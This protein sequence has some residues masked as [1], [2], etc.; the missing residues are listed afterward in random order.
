MKKR[1]LAVT[2]LVLC[3]MFSIVPH[4]LAAG[5]GESI[6]GYAP[7]SFW[8]SG[9]SF[10]DDPALGPAYEAVAAVAQGM[11]KTCYDAASVKGFFEEMMAADFAAVAVNKQKA[12]VFYGDN[13]A[14]RGVCRYRYRGEES[15][16]WGAYNIQWHKYLCVGG[17]ACPARFQE[18][19]QYLVTTAVHQGSEEGMI[20]THLR[21]GSTGF[22]D[23]MTNTDYSLWWPTLAL[24]GKTTVDLFAGD[25]L[26][27]PGE[28]AFMLPAC[29]S[30]SGQ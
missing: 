30:D 26:E 27:N 11:G 4:S 13:G 9:A 22:E 10:L 15:A 1:A 2:L 19:H 14:V 8:V 28:F 21:Y 18:L 6:H 12:F 29:S 23:L 17:K 16:P 7:M 20:H 5:M 25:V 24:Y 3:G